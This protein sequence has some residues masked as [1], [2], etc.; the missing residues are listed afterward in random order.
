VSVEQAVGEILDLTYAQ[1]RALLLLAD[2][3]TKWMK[4]CRE[5][6]T[7]YV[8]KRHG[9]VELRLRYGSLGTE[10]R[11]SEAGRSFVRSARAFSAD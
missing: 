1:T 10:A 2:K 6:R 9:L 4:P 3:P 7:L 11:I 5:T 8:L